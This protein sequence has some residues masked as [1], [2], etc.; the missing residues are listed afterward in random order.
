[1]QAKTRAWI[2]GMNDEDLYKGVDFSGRGM[3]MKPT[4]WAIGMVIIGHA[5]NL[6]GEISALKGVNGLKGYPF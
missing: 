5:H 3:G 1:M 2:I 6:A 4:S